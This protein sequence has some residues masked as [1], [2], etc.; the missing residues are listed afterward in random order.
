M[1]G[2]K[3]STIQ[4]YVAMVILLYHIFNMTCGYYCMRRERE[5]LRKL[6]NKLLCDSMDT[7]KFSYK[8]RSLRLME[9][10]MFYL[11]SQA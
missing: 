3:D 1:I 2:E 6:E 11:E 5:A 7:M 8:N 4:T 10:N 9:L